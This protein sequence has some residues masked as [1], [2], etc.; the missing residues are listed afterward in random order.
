MMPMNDESVRSH[1]RRR[2]EL[3]RWSRGLRCGLV[4]VPIAVLSGVVVREA[5]W[6]TAVGVA[7]FAL[8]TVLSWR[9]QSYGRA[10]MPGLLAGSVPLVLPLALRSTGLCCVGGVCLPLCML[11]CTMGGL[12]AG[13]SLGLRSAAEKAER[14][15]FLAAAT[16]IAALS[17]GLGCVMV[18]TAG[19]VGMAIAMLVT[20]LPTAMAA[21]ALS[22]A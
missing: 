1:L 5:V 22:R 13:I 4:V 18:G 17:G 10:V 7:L 9:G 20:A 8:V 19:I 3:G 16:A 6:A 21:H 11:A 12:V 14:W 2:Y 15:T